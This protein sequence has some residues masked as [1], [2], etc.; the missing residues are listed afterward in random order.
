MMRIIMGIFFWRI[1]DLSCPSIDRQIFMSYMFIHI[2]ICTHTYIQIDFFLLQD[3]LTNTIFTIATSISSLS[4]YTH[5]R[6][7]EFNMALA[8]LF[9]ASNFKISSVIKPVHH[10]STYFSQILLELP[11]LTQS[12]RKTTTKCVVSGWDES[13]V[14]NRIFCETK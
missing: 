13:Q 14:I 4:I 6:R 3:G 5:Q 12:G 11:N 8:L 9:Q 10:V 1:A 7:N 2:H